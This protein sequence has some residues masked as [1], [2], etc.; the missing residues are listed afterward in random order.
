MHKGVSYY[1]NMILVQI[2]FNIHTFLY[3]MQYN[4]NDKTLAT[5]SLFFV[6]VRRRRV[7]FLIYVTYEMLKDFN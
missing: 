5:G 4:C 1:W 3:G 2:N 6:N 7:Q